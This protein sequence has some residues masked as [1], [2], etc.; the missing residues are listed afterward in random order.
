MFALNNY[1]LFYFLHG[2][3]LEVSTSFFLSFFNL[4]GKEESDVSF[5]FFF[6]VFFVDVASEL[7]SRP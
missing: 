4:A 3:V 5:P 7:L 1:L 6:L 2:N